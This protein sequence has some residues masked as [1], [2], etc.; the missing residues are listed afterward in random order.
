MN[1]KIQAAYN[2]ARR[3]HHDMGNQ[4]QALGLLLELEAEEGKE[5]EP[6]PDF[7]IKDH[8]LIGAPFT[9][10]ADH[11]GTLAPEAIII[12]YTAGANK[13]GDTASL[14]AKDDRYV[15]AHVLIDRDGGTQQFVPFNVRAYHAGASEWKGRKEA[16]GWAIG[17]EITNWGP[18]VKR[19]GV[20]YTWPG[21]FTRQLPA[22]LGV[23]EGR[24]KNPDCQYTGWEAFNPSQIAA[25]VRVCKQLVGAYGIK[26]ILGH[27]DIAPGRKI[28]P[29]PAFPMPELRAAVGVSE[30]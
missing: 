10:A 24:H 8:R 22:G 27:D 30:P 19:N 9:M 18:L 17:I 28:D 29:G 16:N 7:G 1:S 6:M 13:A 23:F 11:G 3:L 26:L 14:T 25:V 2:E 5:P 15:S 20:W 21:N 4:L 12:H